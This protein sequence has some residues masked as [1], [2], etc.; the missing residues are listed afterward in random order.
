[1]IVLVRTYRK[2]Y[3]WFFAV[4]ML[5]VVSWAL[6][7]MLVLFSRSPSMVHASAELFYIG[8]M[9]IPIFIWFFALSFPEDRHL[10][11][12]HVVI[13]AIPFAIYSFLFLTHLDFFIKKI[14]ITAGLNVPTPNPF[15]FTLYTA[16][17]SVFFMLVYVTFFLKLRRFRGLS[18]TQL[19]YTF[20]GAFGAS[21]PALITNLSLPLIG[22]RGLIWIG[23]F[24]T[25][26]FAASVTTAI[27]RHKLFDI[28]FYTVRATAYLLTVFVAAV[29][30]VIPAVVLTT[31]L[32]HTSLSLGTVLLLALITLLVATLFQPLGKVFKRLTNRLFYQDVYDAQNFMDRLNEVLVANIDLDILLKQASA[33]I[34]ESLKAEFCLFGIKETEFRGRRI[35]GTS[36]KVFSNQDIASVRHIT[37]HQSAITIVTDD[38]SGEQEPLRKLL[39][40]NDIAVLS[41]LVSEID[42]Q[43]EGLGYLILGTKRSG[44]PYNNQD[45]KI[46]EIITKELFIAIQNSLHFEEIENFNVTLEHR[47]E[48]ATRKLRRTNEKL[49]LLDET[50]DDFISMAS[51]QLRTPLTSVKGY[52]SMVLDGDAGKI[53][54]MQRKLLGQSF[55]SAQRMVYLISDLLNV[56]RLKTGKFVI[57][58]IASNLAKVVKDEI[59]QLQDTA[60]GRNLEL[61]FDKPEHFPTLM[62]DE[63]KIRQVIM[64]FIDNAI[65]YTPSGGHITVRLIEKPQTIEFT[66]QDD[67]IGV[68][69]YEQH[70][71]FSKFYRAENAKRARPDG[72]GLGLFMAKKVIIAQGGATIFKSQQNK[73]STFGFSFAKRA[74]LPSNPPVLG[75]DMPRK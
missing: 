15:A 22:Q 4:T 46:I 66:V 59:D 7:D 21:L 65:Y 52:V 34:A 2:A 37:P 32:L 71:L 64:N 19:A 70:H 3:G 68:P 61:V 43:K 16:F 10:K 53:N 11:P 18:K 72:T 39:A 47:I 8:P 45:V 36:P 62:L 63:T 73:G 13:A 75:A 14:Q 33:V 38:L 42:V 57:E 20:Y 51:H 26:L 23:P 40:R 56:S 29:L 41:R 6:G 54:G 49:K 12:K 60:K 67:G 9:T 30:Y 17:F 1:M 69:K 24:F 31:Y 28:R 48:E 27:V 44:N 58:P 50:K 25:L 35:I 5:G 55:I 74:L